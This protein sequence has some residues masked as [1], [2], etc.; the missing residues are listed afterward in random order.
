[1]RLAVASLI[2]LPITADRRDDACNDR[3]GWAIGDAA[4]AAPVVAATLTGSATRTTGRTAVV[5]YVLH[6]RTRTSKQRINIDV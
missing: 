2:L 6:R 4:A 5:A 3:D 1:M